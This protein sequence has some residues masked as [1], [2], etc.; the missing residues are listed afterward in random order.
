MPNKKVHNI[1]EDLMKMKAELDQPI[2]HALS[3][4]DK[5]IR[6]EK[7]NELVNRKGMEI[8]IYQTSNINFENF[9]L[10]ENSKNKACLGKKYWI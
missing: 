10:K 4:E 2:I 9:L 3:F 8:N 7:F 5:E 1:I 6:A